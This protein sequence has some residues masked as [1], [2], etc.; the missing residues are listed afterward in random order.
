MQLRAGEEASF[1]MDV[2]QPLESPVDLYI[3]MDFSYS[4]SDDLS[5]LKKMGQKLGEAGAGVRGGGGEAGSPYR[6]RAAC[7]GRELLLREGKSDTTSR[8][9]VCIWPAGVCLWPSLLSVTSG[10][11][12]PGIPLPARSVPPD[13][14]CTIGP[15][16]S[17]SSFFLVSYQAKARSQCPREPV[18]SVWC[19]DALLPSSHKHSR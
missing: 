3:L 5:N 9:D 19:P 10:S 14:R 6:Q 4:M 17:Q 7:M 16:L 18:C 2:F 8:G 15:I 11:L 1:D 13:P 12:W